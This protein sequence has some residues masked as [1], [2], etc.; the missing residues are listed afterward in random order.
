MPDTHTLTDRRRRMQEQLAGKSA[1]WRYWGT[2]HN[3]GLVGRGYIVRDD[4]VVGTW[5]G[6]LQALRNSER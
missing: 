6:P 5:E 4:K 3:Y 1:Y 2:L